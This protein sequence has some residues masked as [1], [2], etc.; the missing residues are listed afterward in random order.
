MSSATAT[1]TLVETINI[2]ADDFTDNFLTCPTCMGAYDDGE[3]TPKL[4]PCSHTLC[5]QCLERIASSTA[6]QIQTT[7]TSVSATP[8]GL[9][10]INNSLSRSIAA[11]DAAMASINPNS[12]EYFNASPLLNINSSRLS[13]SSIISNASRPNGGASGGPG[14]QVVTDLCIRCPICRETIILPRNG[15]IFNLPPSFII[16]QLIDLVK[17]RRSRDVIPRCVNHTNEELL[18]CET[19]D[20]A[21]CSIC[22]S[23]FTVATNADHII[24]PFSIALKR[25][26]EIYL[27]KSSQCLNS[28]SLALGNVQREITS[29]NQT[30][31]SVAEKVEASFDELK[32]LV[33]RRK[34]Q[35][36]T[37]L[38]RVRDAKAQ[39]LNDQV[40]LI[41][42]E[43]Q[44][45]ENELKQYEQ[46]N[47]NGNVVHTGVNSNTAS[48]SES[49]SLGAKIQNIN[50]KLDCLRTLCEP[51]ENSFI[52]YEFLKPM[53]QQAAVSAT[54]S[55]ELFDVALRGFGRFKTSNTYPPLCNA[56]VIDDSTNSAAA[57]TN[58]GSNGT[59]NGST[60]GYRHQNGGG[61]GGGGNSTV[62]E[63][64]SRQTNGYGR[65]D[66]NVMLSNG[67]NGSAGNGGA[68][69]G[70]FP[71]NL[72]V[73]LQI[74]T[75]D[76]YGNKQ[77]EGGD[78]I[79]A[80]V[81]DPMGRQQL[82]KTTTDI[83]DCGNGMY[84]FKI[85]PNLIG[86]LT[87]NY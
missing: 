44:M 63:T 41:V 72:T 75:V 78:P 50:E 7:E 57:A 83:T 56:H 31:E 26:T 10:T 52:N 45:V 5:R 29:L 49:K 16:N 67:M 15:G 64:L 48:N 51:R 79:S 76:Y 53:Q 2:D 8:A 68:N 33:D 20:K 34:V 6:V 21:F 59:T 14:T 42:N 71:A 81:S 23:H 24:I 9:L 47:G 61:G 36:L 27:F 55:S 35:V 39:V 1:S 17:S 32:A 74:E 87:V 70:N 86:K 65:A 40:K 58:G 13:N 84:Q 60:N 28:F 54:N 3:H 69:G 19:C 62:Y 77:K 66:H 73:R 43:K 80:L 37:E 18:Y 12:N 11:A 30:A 85:V 38:K 22:E 46:L 4:L 25:I 82:F